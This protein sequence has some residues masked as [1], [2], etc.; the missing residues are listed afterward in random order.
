MKCSLNHE[1][2]A[3][4][5]VLPLDIHVVGCKKGTSEHAALES[6]NTDKWRLKGPYQGKVCYG[7]TV[8]EEGLLEVFRKEDIVY[9]TAE[10][11]TELADLDRGKVF[12]IG[13]L[14]DRNRHKVANNLG[15]GCRG[16]SIG[17]SGLGLGSMV[18]GLGSRV[19]SCT[20]F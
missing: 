9:L 3:V 10:G 5:V 6:F 14:V 12:V 19:Q 18:M 8:H 2:P 15:L 11:E 17:P 7:T 1:L 16:S 20:G 4:Q 13:G